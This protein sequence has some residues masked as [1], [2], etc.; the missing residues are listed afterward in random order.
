MSRK[1][2]RSSASDGFARKLT[3]TVLFGLIFG[4]GLVTGQRLL[5]TGS[6]PPLVAVDSESESAEEER[7]ARETEP[8]DDEESQAEDGGPTLS[9]YERLSEGVESTA[10]PVDDTDEADGEGAEKGSEEAAKYT[11]HISA[12]PKRDRARKRLRRLEQMGLDPY[13]VAAEL[14]EQGTYY[15]IRIGEFRSMEEARRF[16]RE[17]E[18]KRGVE[19]TVTPL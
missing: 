6:P 1:S 10:N 13:L 7:E 19:A 16:Q 18:R 17:L 5:R 11:L 9:F 14:P 15:R 12:Y 4:A 3:W 8:S 2:R